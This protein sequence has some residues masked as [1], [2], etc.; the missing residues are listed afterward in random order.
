M[1]ERSSALRMSCQSESFN[2]LYDRYM[3]IPQPHRTTSSLIH[4]ANDPLPRPLA[5]QPAQATNA[6]SIGLRYAPSPAPHT[7]QNLT[8]GSVRSTSPFPRWWS[9]HGRLNSLPQ[10]SPSR[11]ALA[12]RQ[13]GRQD[14]RWQV[15]RSQAP[16]QPQRMRSTGFHIS[17]RIRHLPLQLR[18]HTAPR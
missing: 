15:L 6:F 17:R 9:V 13:T 7:P 18:A 10:S 12:D 1:S 5:V 14:G 3:A 11:P 8:A 4:P 16:P 2:R